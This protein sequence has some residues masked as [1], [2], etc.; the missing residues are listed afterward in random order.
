MRLKFFVFLFIALT[1]GLLADDALGT[2]NNPIKMYF[3]PSGE[4]DRIITNGDFIKNYLEKETGYH[5]KTAVPLSY[6]AVIEA[7]GANQCDIA[8]LATFAYIAAKQKYDAKIAL[9]TIRY[10]LKSYRGQFIARTD[11]KIDSLPDIAG[12]TVAYT[13]PVSTSGYI[14]PSALLKQ[15][16]IE[17]RSF[18]FVGGHTQ[19]VTAVYSGRTDVACTYWSPE[20][21]GIPQDARKRVLETFPDVFKKTKIVGFTDWIPND[22]VTFRKGVPTLMREKIVKALMDFVKTP[23]GKK[24]MRDLYEIDGLYRS[25]DKHYD[26]VRKTIKTLGLDLKE[27]ID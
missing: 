17:P 19:A 25:T 21:E 24:I 14:Y 5:F 8:W 4:V 13:D 18:M 1:A 27:L 9:T 26:V 23:E 2:K 15:N 6:A 10:G 12:K 20:N 7:M 3:V 11:S 22:T 16:N